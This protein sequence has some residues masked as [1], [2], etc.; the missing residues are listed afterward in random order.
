VRPFSPVW[1]LLAAP[2]SGREGPTTP[3]HSQG[4]PGLKKMSNLF[5][6]FWPPWPNSRGGQKR[7]H[8]PV[9][10]SRLPLLVPLYIFLWNFNN[11]I[12]KNCC[13][14]FPAAGWL[15]YHRANRSEALLLARMPKTLVVIFGLGRFPK[16]PPPK[17]KNL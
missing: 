11:G 3:G 1:A 8:W 5:C 6:S 15:A 14:K 17:N 7:F 2:W 16:Q 12:N 9:C 10:R 13:Q 4:Q